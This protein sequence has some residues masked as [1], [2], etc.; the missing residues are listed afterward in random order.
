MKHIQPPANVPDPPIGLGLRY[1]HLDHVIGARPAAG[2]FEV[3]PENYMLDTA[4]LAKL[5][6]IRM[7][8]PLSLH[9][10]G[11]SLGSANGVDAAH[12]ARLRDLID[13]LDPF[14]VSDHLSWS[15][16]G[17][18][19]LN[20]LL[21][22]P[23]T[24]DALDVVAR[25]VE[26]VQAA[27]KRQILIENPS[28]YLRFRGG[29]FDEPEILRMLAARTGCGLL[30]DVNNVHV[31]AQNLR[32]DAN[33]YLEAFPFDSVKEI[34]LAG[35]TPKEVRGET[36]LIDDHG[37]RVSAP[38]LSLYA[39]ALARARDAATLIEWDS[40]L[41]EFHVLLE[42]RDRAAAVARDALTPKRAARLETLQAELARALFSGDDELA[43][44]ITG[45][46]SIHRN[47]VRESLTAALAA[48]YRAVEQLVGEAFFRQCALQFIPI[49]PPRMPSLAGYGE[50]F[51]EFL[52]GLDS[53]SG[54]P[55]LADVAR[56]EWQASRAALQ[57]PL[58]PLPAGDLKPLLVQDPARLA[59]TAQ[60]GLSYLASRFPADAIWKFARDGGNGTAPPLDNDPVF[61][62]IAPGRDGVV[63]RRL[64]EAE[65]EFRRAL[66]SGAD[67]GM[68]AERALAADPLFVLFTALRSFLSDGI[69]IDCAYA[70]SQPHFEEMRPCPC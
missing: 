4:G 22:L 1:P 23:Y 63:F 16:A 43:C 69:F 67:I 28:A 45:H 14:L 58:P 47:N 68:A 61:L 13:R 40:A 50:E 10:V 53:C 38:V 8:Y 11:L 7:D 37:S 55:Y 15:I 52:S 18:V 48:V 41:P 57:E 51:P 9:A 36:I 33:A 65:F 5:T 35:H 25:N 39:D 20:D 56:L 24:R 70:P 27:L 42:E 34:H 30:L 3:H 29:A 6:R 19:Y 46:F 66:A 31:S 44:G 26:T 21:P 17:G 49:H 60:P 54:L 2:F 12:L 64:E 62:E 59:F 32:F